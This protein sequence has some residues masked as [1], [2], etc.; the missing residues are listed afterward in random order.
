MAPSG[1][2]VATIMGNWAILPLRIVI[3]QL[4]LWI[5]ESSRLPRVTPILFFLNRMDRC[6]EWETME[7][8]NWV[9][10][11]QIIGYLQWKLSREELWMCRQKVI[12]LTFLRPMAL[13]G[14]WDI[15][16]K[17]S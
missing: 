14:E 10:V 17:V 11:I 7:M 13:S 16:M 15:T 6:G 1:E 9:L 12:T 8:V 5:V 3:R 2:L 4:G